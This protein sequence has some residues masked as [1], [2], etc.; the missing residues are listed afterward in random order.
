MQEQQPETQQVDICK[1][2][3][4]I[5]AMAEANGYEDVYITFSVYGGDY[6]HT[7]MYTF[8]VCWGVKKQ[9]TFRFYDRI[10]DVR[11]RFVKVNK[12]LKTRFSEHYKRGGGKSKGEPTPKYTSLDWGFL[13][14]EF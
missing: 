3:R 4:D 5:V 14:D 2:M 12:P 11:Q 6:R 10:E 8:F 1:E 13:P 7:H 9:K